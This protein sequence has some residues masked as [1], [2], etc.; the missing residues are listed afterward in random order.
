VIL[1]GFGREFMRRRTLPITRPDHAMRTDSVSP[2]ATVAGYSRSRALDLTVT[3]REGDRVTISA[4][5]TTMVGAAG[6]TGADGATAAALVKRTSSSLSISVD[7]DLSKDELADLKQVL[8]ALGQAGQREQARGLL[9]GHHG[10]HHGHRRGQDLDTI[11]SI[12]ASVTSSLTVIGGTLVTASAIA[13][14]PE[15]SESDEAT[16]DKAVAPEAPVA[17]A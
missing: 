15:V 13:T 8:K 10:H 16:A 11:A 17:S 12:S 14:P 3:T 9:R 6:A 4:S 7:G 5:Q 1:V 2:A